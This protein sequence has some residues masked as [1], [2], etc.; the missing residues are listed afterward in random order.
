MFFIDFNLIF[1]AEK[2]FKMVYCKRKHSNYQTWGD[3]SLKVIEKEY[4]Y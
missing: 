4:E 2:C 3:Y 1:K